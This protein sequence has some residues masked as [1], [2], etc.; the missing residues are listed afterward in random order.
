MKGDEVLREIEGEA[1]ASFLPIVGPVKG[2]ILAEEVRKAKPMLA[3]EVGTLTGY[4]GILIARE[5]PEDGRLITL[6][7]HPD[8]ARRAEEN[9]SRAGVGDRVEVRVGDAREVIPTLGGVF[10]FLFIDAAKEEYIEYLRLAEPRMRPGTVVVA[11]N[12]GI[13]SDQMKDYLDYVRSGG[14]YRS[15][16]VQVGGDGMEISIRL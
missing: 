6:E 3:L 12:A 10:D 11:D 2:R 4:S 15:R 16:Y 14:V 8:E 9:F 7:I 5:L 13:F 1:K